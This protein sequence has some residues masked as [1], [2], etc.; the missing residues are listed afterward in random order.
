MNTQREQQ[1]VSAKET[2]E[3]NDFSRDA[4]FTI[5]CSL[6]VYQKIDTVRQVFYNNLKRIDKLISSVAERLKLF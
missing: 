5:I 6:H 4:T 1:T 2:N 3:C